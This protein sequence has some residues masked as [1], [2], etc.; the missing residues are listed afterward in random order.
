MTRL[1]QPRESRLLSEW[2]QK[3]YPENKVMYRVRLGPYPGWAQKMIEEGVPSELYKIY[4]RWADAII[5]LQNEVILV[6]A[7]IK[8]NPSVIGQI[9]LY[10]TLLP[11]TPELSSIKD[12]PIR[13]LILTAL[14][15]P[16]VEE[17]AKTFG[18]EIAV[19]APTWVIDYLKE[20]RKY[21]ERY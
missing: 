19:Y 7:K 14:R 17:L 2:I 4:Q 8:A 10:A 1:W 9:I 21:R 15:D 16:D 6:E 13:K 12:M 3:T 11:K 5:I 18:I 20:L